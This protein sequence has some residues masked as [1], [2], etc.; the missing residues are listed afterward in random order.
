MKDLGHSGNKKAQVPGRR[1]AIQSCCPLSQIPSMP[2][3]TKASPH[4]QEWKL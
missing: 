1:L 3:L 4:L 2:N